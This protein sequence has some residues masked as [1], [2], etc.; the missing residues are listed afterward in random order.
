M[1]KTPSGV[2]LRSVEDLADVKELRSAISKVLASAPIDES[3]LRCAIWSFVG[4]ERRAGVPPALV[5][6]RLTTLIDGGNITPV[7]RHLELT[8]S[9]ILWCVEE[10][11]G[12]LG[13]D[14]LAINPAPAAES[15]AI[16]A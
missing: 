12:C 14:M 15:L 5:I 11:F 3:A 13:G 8:R 7:S 4:V 6:T 1:N 10:Y 2:L 9:V 16:D